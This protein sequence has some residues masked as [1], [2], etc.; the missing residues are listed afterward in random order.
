MA[1]GAGDAR[2]ALLLLPELLALQHPQLLRG[3]ERTVNISFVVAASG[4]VASAPVS[5][6]S[7]GQPIGRRR[8]QSGTLRRFAFGGGDEAVSVAN[9]VKRATV[10]SV[11]SIA[12]PP[13][14]TR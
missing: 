10:T 5:R 9:S 2:P 3:M 13:S 12:K 8:R 14:S 1:A 11:W 7:G 6:S 4:K